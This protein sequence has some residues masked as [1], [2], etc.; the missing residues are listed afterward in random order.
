MTYYTSQVFG[1]E[2]DGEYYPAAT[3]SI[4]ETVFNTDKSTVNGLSEEDIE[5]IKNEHAQSSII[6]DY[7]CPNCYL[8]ALQLIRI[9]VAHVSLSFSGESIEVKRP[10][11]SGKTKEINIPNSFKEGAEKNK[12]FLKKL[13]GSMGMDVDNE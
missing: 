2:I 4:C 1:R 9:D 5:N 7:V 6:G 3:C 11:K 12:P 10:S 8:H 13:L